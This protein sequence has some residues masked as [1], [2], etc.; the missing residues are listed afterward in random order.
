VQAAGLHLT[1]SVIWMVVRQVLVMVACGLAIG[2]GAVF[3]LG[4]LLSSVLFGV[5]PIDSLSVA[6]TA[7]VLGAVALAAA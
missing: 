6:A 3:A 1:R 4:P 7:A 2:V 5:S